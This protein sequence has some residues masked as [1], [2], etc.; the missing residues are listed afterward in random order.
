MNIA[1]LTMKKMIEY[2]NGD[3]RRIS[4]ALK[5]HGFARNIG[6]LENI[7]HEKLEIL[8]IAS[9]LHDI[10][11]K[12]SEIKYNSSAAKY[13]E[14]EGPPVAVEL[15]EEFCLEDQFVERVCYLIG[16]HHSYSKIDDVDFQILIES[17]FLVNAFEDD[18][19]RES[20]ESFKNKYFKTKTGNLYL[21]K[22]Y[23]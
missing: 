17:D 4:H 6:E 16:N 21:D 19:N 14:I 10:G 13:Q 23:K 3:A 12:N 11:I 2:F 15:L 18:L 22:M 1:S 9:I 20:I 7:S 5:V 8:E